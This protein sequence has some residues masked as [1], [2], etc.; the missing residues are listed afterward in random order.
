MP[1]N[2][3]LKEN[4]AQIEIQESKEDPVVVKPEDNRVTEEKYPDKILKANSTLP[5]PSSLIEDKFIK[6]NQS[7][8]KPTIRNIKKCITPVKEEKI[9]PIVLATEEYKKEFELQTQIKGLKK[10]DFAD[11]Q[12]LWEDV[13]NRRILEGE[14]DKISIHLRGYLGTDKY[15]SEKAKIIA[16]IESSKLDENFLDDPPVNQRKNNQKRAFANWKN[17]TIKILTKLASNFKNSVEENDSASDILYK[18][19]KYIKYVKHRLFKLTNHENQKKLSK[20][21]ET[22]IVYKPEK[23]SVN[24]LSLTPIDSMTRKPKLHSKKNGTERISRAKTPNKDKILK[25]NTKLPQ[26]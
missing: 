25:E 6:L 20:Q 19:A 9:S 14:K 2:K 16:I 4:K 5:I 18:A 24:S 3:E 22:L 17:L 21:S 12:A 11:I 1:K 7:L 26:I 10:L 15:D 23:W 8:N 13:I